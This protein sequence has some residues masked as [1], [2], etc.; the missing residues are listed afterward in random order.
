MTTLLALAGVVPGIGAMW[1][2]WR[3]KRMPFTKVIV[4]NLSDSSAFVSIDPPGFF[5]QP[6]ESAR[7]ER[8][9]AHVSHLMLPGESSL[10]TA[11]R[12]MKWVRGLQGDDKWRPPY[13]DLDDPDEL[14]D[15]F[16]KGKSGGCRRCA[17][18]LLAA[19]VALGFKARLVGGTEGFDERLQSHCMVEIWV[20]EVKSWILLDPTLDTLLMV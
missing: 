7:R 8:F 10:D 16:Q 9:E 18:V 6:S 13:R 3:A 12:L 19:L 15:S 11:V 17:I 20:K 4:R 2:V 5:Q 1:S 14:L